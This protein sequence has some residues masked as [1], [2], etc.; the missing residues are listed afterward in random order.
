MK[1]VVH[2]KKDYKKYPE[3]RC[4]D[5]N[6]ITLCNSC[7]QKL[8]NTGRKATEETKRK[9]SES[10]KGQVSW[11]KGKHHKKESLEKLSKAVKKSP[12][13][14]KKILATKRKKGLIK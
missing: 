14:V 4:E 5:A 13:T 7:H 11:M 10:H 1:I 2:H 12:E 3:L 8:H 6:G 9:L